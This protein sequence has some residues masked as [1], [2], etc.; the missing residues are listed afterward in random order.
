MAFE[1]MSLH[2]LLSRWFILELSPLQAG[3]TLETWFFVAIP[4]PSSPDAE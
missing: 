1:E 3:E 2:L 4:S